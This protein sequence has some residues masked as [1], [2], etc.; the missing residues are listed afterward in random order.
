MSLTIYVKEVVNKAKE[1]F[2]V[3]PD[4]DWLVSSCG[5]IYKVM[6]SDTIRALRADLN[7][8]VRLC[9][10]GQQVEKCNETSVSPQRINT[11]N[12][13]H[14]ILPEDGARTTGGEPDLLMSRCV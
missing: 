2:S 1:K 5:S 7:Q 12:T 3:K 14:K 4:L 9:S 11:L 13:G 6:V 8:W 10:S